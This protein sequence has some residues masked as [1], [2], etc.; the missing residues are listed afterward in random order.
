MTGLCLDEV[1]G[2]RVQQG[3]VSAD[4]GAGS[5]GET[6][7]KGRLDVSGESLGEQMDLVAPR[8]QVGRQVDGIALSSASLGL[9]V[10]D[11]ECDLQG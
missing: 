8:D 10:L 11:D 2:Q 6:D 5:A 3:L 7:L 4:S 1:M 9:G